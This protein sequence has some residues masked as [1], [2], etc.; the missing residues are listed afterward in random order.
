[1]DAPS[2][3]MDVLLLELPPH[4][5]DATVKI[6]AKGIRYRS[7]LVFLPEFCPVG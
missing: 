7:L 3:T 6:I 4:A 5:M 1:M 2:P